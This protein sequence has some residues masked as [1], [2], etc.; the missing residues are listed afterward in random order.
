MS[1]LYYDTCSNG[2]KLSKNNDFLVIQGNTTFCP[3]MCFMNFTFFVVTFSEAMNT[4]VAAQRGVL[5][6]C[7][8]VFNSK[9]NL[10]EFSCRDDVI[11]IAIPGV[12]HIWIINLHKIMK[13]A[14]GLEIGD[15][16]HAHG[17]FVITKAFFSALA[18][19]PKCNIKTLYNFTVFCDP[20]FFFRFG[21][22]HLIGILSCLQ[23]GAT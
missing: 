14:V 19:F 23:A 2:D 10:L 9:G 15:F 6:W 16:I 13:L 12:K 3:V 11:F 17:S 1:F 7:L 22:F 4:N 8:P 5:W 18:S 20:Q 21:D